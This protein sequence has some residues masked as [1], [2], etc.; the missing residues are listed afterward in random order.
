MR[1]KLTEIGF[2][3]VAT[4]FLDVS[5]V[6]APEVRN[7]VSVRFESAAGDAQGACNVQTAPT[8]VLLPAAVG[9]ADA[10]ADDVAERD[11]GVDGQRGPE[12]RDLVDAAHL[13]VGS[14]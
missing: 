13:V 14:E 10:V 8:A 12:L 7:R 11:A 2:V 3:H 6:G 5:D 1:S 4:D 9:V